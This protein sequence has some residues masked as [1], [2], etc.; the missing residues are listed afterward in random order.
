MMKGILRNGPRLWILLCLSIT[1]IAIFEYWS[2]VIFYT[3][4]APLSTNNSTNVFMLN[5]ST[6][7]HEKTEK[8]KL[9]S[10]HPNEILTLSTIEHKIRT[11][12]SKEELATIKRGFYISPIVNEKFK[13][14]F[15]WNEKAGCSY[16]KQV[17]QFLVGVNG[18]NVKIDDE[19][20]HHPQRNGLSYL[21]NYPDANATAML[22][23]NDWTKAAFVREPRER[24]LSCYF[25]KVIK[26]DHF[27]RHCHNN[28]KSFSMFLKVIRTCKDPH[29]ESQ[30]RAPKWLYEQMMIGK[31]PDISNFTVK[32][33]TKIGAYSTDIQANLIQYR[34]MHYASNASSLLHQ[35]YDKELQDVVFDLYKDD[36][37]VFSFSKEYF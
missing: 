36:Y 23:S 14:I 11:N 8:Q 5:L 34:N 7:Y 32:L 21:C 25:D 17:M 9:T 26:E 30:V 18:S 15:F 33:L 22:L 27:S 16:W 24:I 3:S 2:D 6:S 37:E 35:F 19:F 12:I 29:W 1:V 4:R 13:L 10:I 28:T 20:V 31:M